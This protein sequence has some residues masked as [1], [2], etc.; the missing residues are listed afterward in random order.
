VFA[1]QIA[2]DQPG[3]GDFVLV[4]GPD[5]NMISGGV[6]RAAPG[7][8][9]QPAAAASAGADGKG[10]GWLRLAPSPWDR[11]ATVLVVAGADD[12]GLQAA[13][14]ALTK[15][16]Q[17]AN[18]HGGTASISAGLPPQTSP[19]ADSAETAPQALAPRL[20]GKAAQPKAST[21]TKT[22]RLQTW[23]VVGA[24]LLGAFVTII[25]A[26]LFVKLRPGRR[27]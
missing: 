27:S 12:A 20:V 17:L 21:A 7:L 8:F 10:S 22:R 6:E 16:T 11:N 4:G 19:S 18:L 3:H 9:A 26:L 5:R 1:D 24:V 23:Q 25:G 2:L 14:A 13:A 15:R